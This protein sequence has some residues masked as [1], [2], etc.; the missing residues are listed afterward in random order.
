MKENDD[1]KIE[2]DE[3]QEKINDHENKFVQDVV[4]NNPLFQKF[5][6]QAQE[7]SSEIAQDLL[8]TIMKNEQEIERLRFNRRKI[9]KRELDKE[10][11]YL[12]QM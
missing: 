9:I 4:S 6:A 2:M 10:A 3:I 12:D 7:N 8:K 11:R 1:L 5:F